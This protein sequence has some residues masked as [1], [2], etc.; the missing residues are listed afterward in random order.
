MRFVR[1]LAAIGLLLPGVQTASAGILLSVGTNDL[2][3]A[4][5]YTLDALN[6]YAISWTLDRECADCSITIQAQASTINGGP[7]Q[8]YL[9]D[10]INDGTSDG[11]SQLFATG[12][13]GIAG[14]EAS[15]VLVFNDLQLQARTYYL[16]LGATDQGATGD[17]G[18]TSNPAVEAAGT[19]A[20][21]GQWYSTIDASE[22]NP[23]APYRRVFSELDPA[24]GTL[25]YE[26]ATPE[27][28]PPVLMLTG[29]AGLVLLRRRMKASKES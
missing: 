10:G 26:V 19:S 5:F 14:L 13:F 9:T 12:P 23:P 7:F 22:V 11:Y 3:I 24:S 6:S 15:S 17:L 21:G 4:N 8:A 2:P 18:L 28:Y 16:V 1:V 29:M 25:M 20:P 27:P